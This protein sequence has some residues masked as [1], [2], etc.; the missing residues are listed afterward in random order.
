MKLEELNSAVKQSSD[1]SLEEPDG[2]LD[3]NQTENRRA[4][5][6]MAVTMVMRRVIVV[7]HRNV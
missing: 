6:S 1:S 5:S 2:E 3:Q 4:N 7:T